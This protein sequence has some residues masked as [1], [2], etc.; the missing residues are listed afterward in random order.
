[1]EVIAVATNLQLDDGLIMEAVA[2]GNHRTKREAVTKALEEYVRHLRQ[3]RILSLFGQ[4]DFQ[5]EYDYK[6]QRTRT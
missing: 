6:N 5:P 4:I 1:V 2:L 3:G